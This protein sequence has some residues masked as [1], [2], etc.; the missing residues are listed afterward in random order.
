[1]T[2]IGP[3]GYGKFILL[4]TNARVLKEQRGL[5]HDRGE[6]DS[7]IHPERNREKL[8]ILPLETDLLHFK[9]TNNMGGDL[10][11]STPKKSARCTRN[12]NISVLPTA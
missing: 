10:A 6:R 7:L 2:I 12:Y 9:K 5:R 8:A 3:N 11:C 4:K 1:M